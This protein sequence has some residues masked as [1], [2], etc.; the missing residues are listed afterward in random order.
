MCHKYGWD[1]NLLVL[2]LVVD[3]FNMCST[4]F[5]DILKVLSE[6]TILAKEFRDQ[7]RCVI[8]PGRSVRFWLDP[9]VDSAPL[10]IS[11]P[12]MFALSNNKN[13]LIS[14]VGHNQGRKWNWQLEFRRECFGWEKDEEG[15]FYATVNSYLPSAGRDVIL[16]IG[17]HK[18]L[19]SVKAICEAMEL[20]LLSPLPGAWNIPKRLRKIIPPKLSLFLW[21]AVYNKIAV[22][23]NLVE[24]GMTLENEGRCSLCG[25]VVESVTH[26]LLACEKTYP[27]WYGVLH[28]E[29]VTWCCPRTVIDLLDEWPELRAKSDTGLWDLIP[30]SLCWSIWLGR[31]DLIFQDKEFNLEQIWDL[32]ISRIAWWIKAWWRECPYSCSDFLLNFVEIR[33]K[34][35]KIRSRSN[36]WTPPPA[37]SLKFNVDGSSHG[38]PGRSGIGG[39]LK[40]SERQTRGIFSKATGD[41]WAYEAEVKA[42]LHALMFCHQFQLRHILI[43]S[44]SA[45]AVGWVNNKVNRPWKVIQDLN[46]IDS[47]CV[48]V[49]C[50]GI[51]HI[52]RE[53][54]HL[55]DYLAKTGCSRQTEIWAMLR[56]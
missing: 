4:V 52:F 24:R 28:R 41:L 55:A 30:Y 15:R 21:Q 2:H 13:A 47:L 34:P 18:G 25:L 38:M 35:P 3:R 9:W 45:L 1:E 17:D 22:K 48:E 53:S 12:R 44:D 51:S 33:L 39:I 5:Q 46:L 31:N 40:D 16:W 49:D 36:H 20:R 27:L 54:N 37:G 6:D 19:F 50:L 43:E 11:F 7:I 10:H 29:G 26:L 32:H 14:E 23:S 56:N 8:G 42:I